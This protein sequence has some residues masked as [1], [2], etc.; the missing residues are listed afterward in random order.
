VGWLQKVLGTGGGVSA[1]TADA[2]VKGG[3]MLLDVREQ[4][5]WEA[6]HAPGARHV[7]LGL[8][9]DRIGTIPRDRQVVVVCRSGHRS[10]Q[11][12]ALLARAGVDAVN[13]HGGMR[14]WAGADL[15]VERGDGTPG[16]VA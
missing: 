3:A 4:G 1:P 9:P 8:L 11:A 14:A 13:L 7:P 12:T 10:A 15:P 2:L 5:E 16:A 6:G